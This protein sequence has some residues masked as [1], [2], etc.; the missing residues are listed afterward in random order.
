MLLDSTESY[1]SM[2]M[3]SVNKDSFTLPFP[4][5]EEMDYN[6]I[7]RY[8]WI[9]NNYIEVKEDRPRKGECIVWFH[10]Y[11]ILENKKM[12]IYIQW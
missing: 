9:S 8:G 5:W 3:S 10:L 6:Y 11:K 7:Q 1:T 12:K 4:V 2:I